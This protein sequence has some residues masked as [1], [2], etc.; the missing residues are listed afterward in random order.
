MN[1]DEQI[2][3]SLAETLAQHKLTKIR[4]QLGDLE[5]EMEQQPVQQV[6]LPLAPQLVEPQQLGGYPTTDNT[7][8]S[9]SAANAPT[10]DTPQYQGKAVTAPFVGTVYLSPSPD[11]EP[12]IQEGDY[13]E[14]GDTVLIVESMKVMTPIPAVCSGK[15]MEILI[16]NG[17]PAEYGQELIWIDP[18][19]QK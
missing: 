17:E 16:K 13:I 5:I 9:E 10:S 12:F 3:K 18:S 6:A 4:Y 14:E 1:H 7:R 8:I 11:A 2:L 19:S 15:V